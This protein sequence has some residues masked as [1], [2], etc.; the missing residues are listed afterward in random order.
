MIG[1][2]I[3]LQNTEQVLYPSVTICLSNPYWVA[4]FHGDKLYDSSKNITEQEIFNLTHTPDMNDVLHSL[5][6]PFGPIT[7]R[8]YILIISNSSG[9]KAEIE[10]THHLDSSK[11]LAHTHYAIDAFPKGD[12]FLVWFPV[13]IYELY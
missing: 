13:K 6:Q 1:T 3:S 5:T 4:E 8:S 9:N 7:N 11:M 10:D 12:K 2:T